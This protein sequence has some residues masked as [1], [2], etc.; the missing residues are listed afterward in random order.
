[1]GQE[2]LM[3]NR[4]PTPIA[5][6]FL[7]ERTLVAAFGIHGGQSGAPGHVLINGQRADPKRQHVLRTG[8]TVLLATPGGG[9]HGDPVLRDASAQAADIAAGYVADPADEVVSGLAPEPIDA[10]MPEK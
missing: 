1:L 7:A 8:D 6:S 10:M 3:E 9:G 4:S 5:V 2:I